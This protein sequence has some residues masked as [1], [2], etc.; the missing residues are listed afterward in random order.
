VPKASE[1]LRQGRHEELWQ[2]CCGFLDLDI[3]QFME[4]QER[5]LLQQL[6]LIN[7]SS[8]GRRLTRGKNPRTLDEF[9]RYVPLTNYKDY[10]Q[11]FMEKKEDGLP[12]QPAFWVRTSGKSGDSPFKLVPMAQGYADRLSK[13][14]YGI[15]MLCC[16]DGRGDTS[17]IPEVAKILYSVAPR[18]Y[19]SGTFADLLRDQASIKYLPHLEQAENLSFEERI[20]LGFKQALDEGL[21]YFFGLSLV[22]V[23]VG[24]KLTEN[25]GKMKIGSFIKKPRALFRVSR[26]LLKSKLQR[27]KLMPKDI[28]PIKG[29]IGSG[30]DSWVYKDKIKEL[31]GRN[32]LDLYSATEAGIIATQAWDY[33]AMT[34]I[35]DLNFLE[36]IP[37]EETLKW[38]MDRSYQMKTLLLN[39]V[40]AG[41]C[42]ELVITNF[43]GGAMMRYRIGD[44]IKITSLHNDKMQI[45]TPQM[46]FERRADDLI[47]FMVIKLNEK[48]IWR[49]IEKAGILYEDWAAYKIPGEP[50]LNVLI[51]PKKSTAYTEEGLTGTLQKYIIDE[52]RSSYESSG[53]KEDWRDSLDF[54]VKVTLLDHGTFARYTAMKQ[55]EGAD[56]AHIKPPHVN[57]PER[58]LSALL[59]QEDEMIIVKKSR[60][61]ASTTPEAKVVETP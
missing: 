25:S 19:I 21:D 40:E 39:E 1:L 41:E 42:Y 30:I 59:P 3:K 43:H 50:V 13:I 24:E 26:G 8:L 16:C 27:R 51:E 35:P 34:F 61:Q 36:F 55:A 5:L 31:W 37:E 15:G 20:A 23:K 2:M 54:S 56:L 49:A 6:E 32:P 46:A 45:G 29:I 14:L 12:S 38:Q 33:D 7:K 10:S 52:G 58:V 47:N 44:I 17:H 18:P 9:R 60:K 22:L 53:I 28:W 48:Q 11:D 4:I 57:P